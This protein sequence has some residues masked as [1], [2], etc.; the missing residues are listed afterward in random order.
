MTELTRPTLLLTGSKTPSPQLK[1]A[2]QS[3]MNT[4]PNR[5]LVVLEGEG[6]NAMDTIPE[7]LAE[8]VTKFLQEK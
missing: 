8:I 4:L 1:R 2:I 5:Q 7:R 3:L 6:H